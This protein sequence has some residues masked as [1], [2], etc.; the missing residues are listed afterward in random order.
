MLYL[1]ATTPG[2]TPVDGEGIIFTVV[3]DAGAPY[4]SPCME[5]GIDVVVIPPGTTSI[6]V[7]AVTGCNAGLDPTGGRVWAV[8]T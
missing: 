5:N 3:I 7:T 2:S 1:E 6:E 4:D 8:S